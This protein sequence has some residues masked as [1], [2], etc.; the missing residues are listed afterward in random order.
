MSLLPIQLDAAVN[1]FVRE[2]LNCTEWLMEA[3]RRLS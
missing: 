1:V 2:F 3:E